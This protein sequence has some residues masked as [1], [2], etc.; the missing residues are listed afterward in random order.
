[1]LSCECFCQETAYEA[2]QIGYNN[3]VIDAAEA[4]E[5]CRQIEQSGLPRH[6]T[7]ERQQREKEINDKIRSMMEKLQQQTADRIA[8][9]QV[10]C[11]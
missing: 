3:G 11:N 1:M 4:S 9:A 6:N 8:R 7:R 5:L 2:V 10:P